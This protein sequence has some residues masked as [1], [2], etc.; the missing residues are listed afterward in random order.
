MHKYILLASLVGLVSA[1][2]QAPPS[3]VLL[4]TTKSGVIPVAP[5][6][7]PGVETI[8]GALIDDGPPLPGFIG[9]GGNASVQSNLP[10]ATY[11]AVLPSANFDNLTGS[12]ITG[13][14]IGSAV[15]GGQG[16]TFNISFSGL[17]DES[18]YGPFG[19]HIHEMPVASGNCTT[20]LGHLD[21]TN[22]GELHSCV[23]A[24]PA[25]CQAGDLAGKHGNITTATFSATYTDLYLSTDPNSSY[26]FG[27]R[28]IVIHSKN[29]TRLTCANFA[30]GTNGSSSASNA[31]ASGSASPS[32]TASASAA[33]SLNCWSIASYA[34]IMVMALVYVI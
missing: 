28:S 10:A 18:L 9:P 14:I 11:S 34:S 23:V 6:P 33:S 32:S 7:F 12:V 24:N 17:P 26:F 22:R 5:T 2:P 21:P 25:S 16:V 19:Y 30:M 13:T 27:N 31:T 15:Q 1:K 3:P 8:E 20:S 4:A 29:A